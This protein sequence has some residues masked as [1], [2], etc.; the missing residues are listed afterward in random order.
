MSADSSPIFLPISRGSGAVV[1]TIPVRYRAAPP[2]VAPALI[3]DDQAFNAAL[4]KL[5]QGTAT[6]ALELVSKLLSNV[7]AKQEEPKYRRVRTSN[8][9]LDATLFSVPGGRDLMLACGFTEAPPDELVLPESISLVRLLQHRNAIDAA[10]K[11]PAA[12]P[13]P[14]QPGAMDVDPPAAEA[15]AEDDDEAMMLA[16]A[17]ALSREGAGGAPPAEED[18]DDML[19]KALALSRENDGMRAAPA[20]APAPA[21]DAQARLQARVRELF[22]EL[23]AGGMA[24][25]EAAAQALERATRE[26]KSAAAPPP[27]PPP[28]VTQP[29]ALLEKEGFEARVKELFAAHKA[30][31]AE[32]NEAAANALKQAQ[33]EQLAEAQ[34]ARADRAGGEGGGSDVPAGSPPGV[35]KQGSEAIEKF[36]RWEEIE[37]V[38]QVHA[39]RRPLMHVP[40]TPCANRRSL[41]PP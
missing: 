7:I 9:K 39:Y 12:V 34:R 25:N 38:A 30:A 37:R 5:V 29:S 21:L 15:M 3:M 2:P 36:E 32:A 24:P 22:T 19:E 20:P 17:L 14:S 26:A 13:P 41:M 6:G 18:D 33:Q 8:A 4:T 40:C 16:Q 10:I 28:L 35:T 27:A 31:G 23:A 1:S 11:A